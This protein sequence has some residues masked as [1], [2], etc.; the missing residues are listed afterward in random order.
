MVE[1]VIAWIGQKLGEKALDWVVTPGNR[2]ARRHDLTGQGAEATSD[3]DITVKYDL[4]YWRGAKAP[5]RLTFRKLDGAPEYLSLPAVLGETARVRLKRGTYEITARVLQLSPRHDRAEILHAVGSQ[6]FWLG[7][8]RTRKARLRP[9]PA[10]VQAPK[11]LGPKP[12][13]KKRPT[14]A[15]GT[16]VGGGRIGAKPVRP[17]SRTKCPLCDSLATHSGLCLVHAAALAGLYLPAKF[18]L[19]QDPS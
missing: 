12:S 9:A 11:R 13:A 17:P 5:V 1:P 4:P 2:K 14:P 7:H 19:R 16:P 6:V 3:L 15:G 8:N 10:L 18:A